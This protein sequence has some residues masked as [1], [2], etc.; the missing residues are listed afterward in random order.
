MLKGIFLFFL[1]QTV[2][3]SPL[4]FSLAVAGDV[5]EERDVGIF[6]NLGSTIPG[7]IFFYDESGRKVDIRDVLSKAPALI[8]PVYF[9]CP[10]VCN[11]LQS[12]LANIIPEVSLK[13]GEDFQIISASF[14]EFDTPELAKSKKRNFM[15]AM[16]SKFP[17]E[18]WKF[19][20]SDKEN[21]TKLMDAIGFKFRRQG[22]DFIHSVVVVAVSKEGK[23]VRYVYGTRILPFDL[24]MSLVEAQKG[25][26]GVSVKRVLS[27]CFSYDPA[28]K[29]YVFNV[30]K[31]SGTVILSGLFIMFLVLVFGGKKTKRGKNE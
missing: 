31:V 25:S 15:A 13:P 10:N 1:L 6:E 21:I 2:F 27:Y 12:S 7:G 11:I 23:I 19:L 20:T 5:P 24:T 16:D 4:F 22:K 3:I 9:T 17:E 28:G 30:M 14:D 8:A 18:H 29:R 26:V